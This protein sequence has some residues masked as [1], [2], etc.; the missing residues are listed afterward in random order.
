MNH[1][2][3]AEKDRVIQMAWED[4]TS[5]DAIR[6]QFALSPGDVIKLMRREMTP[7]SFK[8]WRKRTTGRST[9]HDRRFKAEHEGTGLRRFRCK[10][11][12]G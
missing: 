12:R 1:L 8:M 11:Q 4:R 3:P 6:T 5:F 7:K 2:T 10:S 9:K